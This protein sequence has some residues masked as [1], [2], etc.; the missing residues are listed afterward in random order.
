VL[1]I[2]WASL[3]SNPRTQCF[4]LAYLGSAAGCLALLALTTLRASPNPFTGST[5]LR[6]SGPPA[7]AARILIFD[8]TGR[9][10][11]TAWE[12]SL[13][14]REVTITWDGRDQSGRETP[15]GIYL[16]RVEST[17]GEAVGRLV[18]MQ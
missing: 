14:G 9:L 6:L 4:G 7:A 10:V 15:A 17:G 1:M 13:D 16:L 18:K 11:R 2:G 3:E 5:T 12:G 8:A